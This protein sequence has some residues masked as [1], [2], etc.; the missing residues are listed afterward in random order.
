MS[1]LSLQEQ[2]KILDEHIWHTYH[3][4]DKIEGWLDNF[5][6][7]DKDM[8]HKLLN[9]FVYF[10]S[11]MTKEMLISGIF[12]ER[13]AGMLMAGSPARLVLRV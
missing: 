6:G 10:N 4:N 1:N 7:E 5:Q 12:W 9:H 2:T 8:A 11:Q 3:K 13:P